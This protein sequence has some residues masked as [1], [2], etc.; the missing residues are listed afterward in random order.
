MKKINWNELIEI[1]KDKK[2]KNKIFILPTDTVYGI[3]ASVYNKEGLVKIEKLK[4]RDLGK[5]FIILISK[6][7]DLIKFN[8]KITENQKKFL[9]KIWPGHYTIIFDYND[10]EYSY[11]S[12]ELKSLAFRIPSHKKILQFIDSFGPIVSTSAN[13][14]GEKVITSKN[15]DLDKEIK[16]NWNDEEIKNIDYYL[17]SKNYKENNPS[18]ILK[19]IR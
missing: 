1:S 5:S 7:S 2:N 14:S 16:I 17:E 9:K 18:T 4:K 11:I 8:I 15:M 6:I 13:V 10:Q 12:K 19:I 3:H